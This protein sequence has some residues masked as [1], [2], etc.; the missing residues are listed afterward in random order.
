MSGDRQAWLYCTIEF[1]MSEVELV[2]E[3]HASE[4]YQP[5]VMYLGLVEDE[6]SLAKLIR[7]HCAAHGD[8]HADHIHVIVEGTPEHDEV[9]ASGQLSDF[10]YLLPDTWRPRKLALR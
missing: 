1:A 8:H 7:E 2:D 10:P 6:G 9:T 3:F 4:D 5:R